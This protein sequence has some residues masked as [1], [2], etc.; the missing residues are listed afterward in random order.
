M[1]MLAI[2]FVSSLTINVIMSLGVI[3]VISHHFPHALTQSVV[4]LI[5]ASIKESD[6]CHDFCHIGL[7]IGTI[8]MIS[9]K[10]SVF[11]MVLPS[12]CQNSCRNFCHHFHGNICIPD[13]TF[14]E[15]SVFLLAFLSSFPSKCRHS[16]CRLKIGFR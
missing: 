15:V 1:V 12:K 16:S 4:I 10:V 3:S 9:V 5:G 2:Q 6:F 14:I 11:V 8:V 7:L 13:G